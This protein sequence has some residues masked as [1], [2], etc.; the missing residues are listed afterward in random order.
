MLT[1]QCLASEVRQDLA[2]SALLT[3][4]PFLDGEQYIIVKADSCAHT[5]DANASA[6]IH[7]PPFRPGFRPSERGVQDGWEVTI[8]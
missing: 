8:A 6:I 2:G 3:L 7:R 1:R 5:S 4:G